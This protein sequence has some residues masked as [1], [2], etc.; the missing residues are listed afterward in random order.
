[1]PNIGSLDLS[2]AQINHFIDHGYLKLEAAFDTDL[3]RQGQDELWAAMGLLPDQPDIWT[4]PVIR[5][6]F[7]SGPTFV[8]A[9]N[10][11]RLHRAYTDGRLFTSMDRVGSGFPQS[12]LLF[13]PDPKKTRKAWQTTGC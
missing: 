3:A 2:Q 7:I 13:G 11:P 5:V 6:G 12:S 1:M 4:Q 9:A 10:T 8:K